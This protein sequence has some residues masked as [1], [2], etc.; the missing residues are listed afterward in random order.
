MNN[1]RNIFFFF[2]SF[3][4]WSCPSDEGDDEIAFSSIDSI[5]LSFLNNNIFVVVVLVVLVLVVVAVAI[6]VVVLVVV[7]FVVV[8]V[9]L[10]LLQI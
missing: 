6:V 10:F 1:P 5:C 9:V 7:V 3:C 8:V 2:L 4:F